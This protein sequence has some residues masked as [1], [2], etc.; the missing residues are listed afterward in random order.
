MD[1]DTHDCRAEPHRGI[2]SDGTAVGTKIVKDIFPG[3]SGSGLLDTTVK[4][5]RSQELVAALPQVKSAWIFDAKGR[6]LYLWVADHG[7]MSACS[8]ACAQAWPPLTTI[9]QPLTEMA[10]TATRI[11]RA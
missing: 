10:A 6:A 5:A 8:G 4:P 3:P 11:G 9:R 2:V 1:R 7:A